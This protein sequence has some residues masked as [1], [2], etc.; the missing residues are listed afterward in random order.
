MAQR[1]ALSP[2]KG[3]KA[4]LTNPV[5]I[6]PSPKPMRFRTKN[7]IAD[8]IARI[9]S[10]TRKCVAAMQGPRYSPPKKQGTK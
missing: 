2:N 10:P 9:R 6:G 8:A 4:S 1:R 7:K 3:V 5:A